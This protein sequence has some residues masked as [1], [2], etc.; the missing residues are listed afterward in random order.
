MKKLFVVLEQGNK[1]NTE[2]SI[3]HKEQ[4]N[5]EY[6][7]WYRLNW[8]ADKKDTEAHFYK[9]NIVWTE[10]RSYLFEQVKGKYEYYIFIDDDIKF[11]SNS[12]KSVAEELKYFFTTYNP[13]T[14]TLYGDNWAWHTFNRKVLED[15]KEVFPV[16]AHDLCCHYFQ[17]DFANAMFPV[18]FQGSGRS[19]W[20]SQ[21]IASRLYPNK[22]LVFTKVIV[23]NTESVPHSDHNNKQ[24]IKDEIIVKKFAELI[25]NPKYKQ[26][27]LSWNAGHDQHIGNWLLY[28]YTVDKN[29]VEFDKNKI[30]EKLYIN[31]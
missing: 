2:L 24:F 9:D 26:D 13:L 23:K 3:E 18:F 12:D 11:I 4:F 14:G 17:E 1:C 19:M 20:Y 28:D 15:K 16:M 25:Q 30:K 27:F 10:G 21:F 31:I 8:K 5:T 29:K 22:C 6:C 7:D